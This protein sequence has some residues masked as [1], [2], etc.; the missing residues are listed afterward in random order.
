[1]KDLNDIAD[2]ILAKHRPDRYTKGL[3][4]GWINDAAAE[5]APFIS[6]AEAVPRYADSIL[7]AREGTKTQKANRVIRDLYVT[8]QLPLDWFE[9]GHLPVAVGDQ[10]VKIRHMTE[11]DWEQSA[12]EEKTRADEDYAAR[13]ETV[14]AKRWMAEK[15]RRQGAKYAI[16]LNLGEAD[17]A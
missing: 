11:R 10:R 14:E 15:H 8:G 1:M 5:L 9:L 7:R 2:E 17:A 3:D 4:D 13:L 12:D 16:D 6:P